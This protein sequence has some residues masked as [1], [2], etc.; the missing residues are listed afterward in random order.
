MADMLGTAK[1]D[2]NMIIP[3][4]PRPGLSDIGDPESIV[5]PKIDIKKACKMPNI[6]DILPDEWL[7]ALG[8]QLYQGY[9]IDVQSRSEWDERN[10]KSLKIAM[11]LQERK[12]FPWLGASSVK[13]P[14]LTIAA[15]Q[16]HARA[17]P[18]LVIP[19]DLVHYKVYGPD[20]TG[21]RNQLGRM[22]GQHMTYQCIE[23]DRGWQENM[24]LLLL[25]K[26]ILGCCFKKVYWD[27]VRRKNISECVLPNDLVVNYF[28]KSL[29][30]A[31]RVSHI[32]PMSA[33]AIHTRQVMGLFRDVVLAP[34]SPQP[35]N[36][37][38][39][40]AV[41]DRQQGTTPNMMDAKAPNMLI[42]QYTN[43][44]LDGDGYAE[45]YIITF[46]RDSNKV[47]R[48]V[49]RYSEPDIE[50]IGDGKNKKISRIIAEQTFVK[51]GFIPSPDGGFYDMGFGSLLSSTTH[52]V[53]TLIN[54]LIDA[55]TLSNTAGFFFGKGVKIKGG[56]YLFKPFGGIPVDSTGDDL[57]KN[58]MPIPVR[59]PEGVLLELLKFLV[60]YG[61]RICGATDLNVGITPD[62]NTP[63][64]TSR[65]A[66]EAGM[67]VLAAVFQRAWRS[68]C[69]EFR[70]L[71]RLNRTYL[72]EMP[73]NPFQLTRAH[74]LMDPVGCRPAADPTISSD[75]TRI[76]QA[77]GVMTL[78]GNPAVGIDPWQA[79]RRALEA[80]KIS[81]IDT[82]QPQRGAPNAPQ[83]PP[84]PKMLDAETKRI[85]VEGDQ[86]IKLMELRERMARLMTDIS[87]SQAS[88][89]LMEA[90]AQK[91]LAEAKGVDTGHMIAAFEASIGAAKLRHD[92]MT[93]TLKLMNDLLKDF[94][95]EGQGDRNVGT[96]G[97]GDQPGALQAMVAGAGNAAP[98]G[99]PQAPA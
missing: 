38:R 46:D 25:I 30:T 51:Y 35:S 44:D 98:D 45:P 92:A 28:T 78:A 34:P 26:P 22:L 96:G 97:G 56:Q 31:E 43:L 41:R 23:E 37:T 94:K 2:Y 17:Y 72:D 52:S 14:L 89:T 71:Y 95:P 68:E 48:I 16:Y 80:M 40:E 79:G 74:Y 8:G 76:Q 86:K 75:A 11:Q 1:R 49:A 6:C 32:I 60:G 13:F 19:T 47:L 29:E 66:G 70:I 99:L 93:G 33:N 87:V 59:K 77:N 67:K 21:Q 18:G 81:D 12:T 61:E 63:A 24:D 73:P 3:P 15:I 85:K 36:Q 64:E 83:P 58:I 55:G 57:N 53:D 10:A 50:E 39:Q 20:P 84:N 90:Q 91:A 88:I 82:L 54:Q 69:D 9:L 4:L 42:E 62:Q 65:A 7:D 5:E 27:P